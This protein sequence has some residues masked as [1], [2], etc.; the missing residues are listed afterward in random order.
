MFNIFINFKPN[1]TKAY[2]GGN[3]TTY[4]IEKFFKDKYNNFNIKY[5]L[6]NPI[7]IYLIIDPFKDNNYKKYNLEDVIN[8]RNKNNINGKIIIRIN[9]SDITRP[10]LPAELSRE[11]KII[12][13]CSEIDYYICNSNF[14]RNHYKKFI[15]MDQSE[16]IY[17]GCDNSIFYPK[18]FP[19]NKPEKFKIV[20]HHWSNNMNKGYQMYY[21]LW[22]YLVKSKKYEFIFIGKNIPDMFKEVPVIGPYVGLELSNTIR[23]CQIYIT[24][25]IYDSCPNH[26]IEA[27]SCGLPILYRKHEG[28]AKELCELLPKKI[29]ESYSNLEELIEK[30][31][32]IRKNYNEYK[33][34]VI[35]YSNY[36]SINK[37]ISKYGDIF[38]NNLLPNKFKIG[39]I[40]IKNSYSI[41]LKISSTMNYIYLKLENKFINIIPGNIYHINCN[42]EKQ[43]IYL[44]TRINKKINIDIEIFNC[45]LFNNNHK[46]RLNNNKINILF[47][48]DKSYFTPMFAS[49]HSVIKNSNDNINDLCFNFI[50]PFENVNYFQNMMN[51]YRNSFNYTI[52]LIDK[53]ILNEEILYSKCYDGGNHLLNIGNFSRLLIGEIFSY[54][55]L[56]YLDSDSICKMD[57]NKLLKID[58][59]DKF[60][61]FKADKKNDNNKRSLVLKLNTIISEDYCKKKKINPDDFAYYGAPF[62]TD[63][64]IWQNTYSKIIEVVSQHNKS[65]KGIYK[66]FTMSLQN[67]IFYKKMEDIYK[68]IRTLPDLGSNRKEWLKEDLENAEILDWSG[69]YKPW[70]S[71]GL[72][73]EEWEKYNVMPF[74]EKIGEIQFAK[75]TVEKFLI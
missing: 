45:E 37:Q 6:S 26:V 32:I 46:S 54:S 50:I 25:S 20:T 64:N 63:C 29:G 65:D 56:L 8:H 2:G 27:I 60:Y 16:I 55:K 7:D 18:S 38:L 44:Y 1:N 12:N 9:D 17:N 58:T 71:N 47:S 57:V 15:N 43:N 11:K 48:S 74:L 31:I 40:L 4:Y 24:D 33:M 10:N 21:D 70:F 36:F 61:C 66:L 28:G 13:N 51:E 62:L 59:K 5:E 42:L 72:Y 22:L 75:K 3:I 53:M 52:V 67:I 23:D 39:E 49:L 19:I 14:I 73:K 41:T 68:I 69:I 35:E 30:I 34:N